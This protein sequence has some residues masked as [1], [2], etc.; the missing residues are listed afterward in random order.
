MLEIAA[1]A[2]ARSTRTPRATARSTPCS[3]R[4]ATC[5]S[6]AA[7]TTRASTIWS[8]PP[9]S[10]TAPSTGTSG[11]RTSSRACS[12][13]APCRRSARRCSEIPDRLRR[14]TAPT[15]TSALR[16]WLRRYNAAH[17]NE[18]AM[19]RVWVDAA[20][21]D[22]ALRAE[23][24]PLLDWGRRRMARYLRPRGVRRRRHRGRRHGRRC[25]ACSAPGRDPRPRSTRPRTSS[26]ADSWAADHRDREHA[27]S[28]V[29]LRRDRLLPRQGP[30]A[31]PVPVLRVPPRARPGVARAAS[32]RG[33]GHRLRGGD[34]GLQRPRDV[35]VVQH[36][37]R[38][39]RA[40][41]GAA[42]GRRHQR[43]HRAVP[44]RAAVQRPAAHRSI[45]R[46]TPRTAGC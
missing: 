16:R 13:R 8:R 1:A 18:A 44:R 25:S 21:Q 40:V 29:R 17:A 19:L 24:A 36:G 37:R 22:P 46:S 12:P 9:A 3:R 35:L 2:T 23:S 28:D 20:L 26:S 41:A 27:V 45:R 6:S 39:V 38:A 43:D 34:G 4:D 33:H 32:R 30:L 42:R 5:S 10:R 15:G 14:S 11:T 7:T 31:G